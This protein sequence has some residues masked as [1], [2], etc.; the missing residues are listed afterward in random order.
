MTFQSSADSGDIA[1]LHFKERFHIGYRY[2]SLQV[3]GKAGIY[4]PGAPLEIAPDGFFRKKI[5]KKDP[6]E[7]FFLSRKMMEKRPLT[8]KFIEEMVQKKDPHKI[9]FS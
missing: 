4:G 8:K 6:F 3:P 5:R 2:V 1:L 9:E 7:W